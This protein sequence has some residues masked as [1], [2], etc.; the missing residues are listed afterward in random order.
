MQTLSLYLHIPFC[1]HRCGYC[2]FNTYAGLEDII[3]QYVTALAAEIEWAG[4]WN[5]DHLP[6]HTIFFGGGTPSLLPVI[7][8]RRLLDQAGRSF[9][10]SPDLEITLEANPGTLSPAYLRDLRQLGVNRLSLGMQSA[11]PGELALLEREHSYLDVINSFRGARQAGFANLNLDLIFGLPEQQL[12]TWQRSL[13]LALGLQPEHLSLYSLTIEHGTPFAAW[14]GKGLLS[15]PDPDRAADM[16]EWASE[17]LEASG[18]IQYEISNWARASAAGDP[19][20]FPDNACRHNLQYWRNQPYLGC[21]AGAH[22]FF[23]GLRTANVLSPNTY[24]RRMV[25]LT[26]STA[27][28]LAAAARSDSGP[29]VH[30]GRAAQPANS[31]S[32][33]TV[34]AVPIDRKTEMDE[35]MFMGLRLVQEGVSRRAFLDRFGVSL[36]EIYGEQIAR[37]SSL[38]LIEWAA[39][40]RE[41]LR[42]ARKGVLLANQVFMEFIG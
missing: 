40:E 41:R 36:D 15:S 21:G 2:D 37:L 10:L 25:G 24:I 42:L 38:G 19:V 3:P 12:D 5:T 34:S 17:R 11:H 16:Y 14:T 13:E 6:L 31:G 39:P 32:P 33:A 35:T 7:E 9:N 27:A 4:G 18:Y 26:S 30:D 28:G 8:I 1:R 22:G 20:G 29:P 23:R